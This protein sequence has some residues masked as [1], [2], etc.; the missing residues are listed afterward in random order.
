[1]SSENYTE[2]LEVLV[3]TLRRAIIRY[4]IKGY[5]DDCPLDEDICETDMRPKNS[6][7][8]ICPVPSTVALRKALKKFDAKWNMP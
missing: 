2:D 4:A 8:R 7:C 1:M 5:F 3:E 6:Y